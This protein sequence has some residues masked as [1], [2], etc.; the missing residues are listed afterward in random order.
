L[1]LPESKIKVAEICFFSVT[2]REEAFL[3][4]FPVSKGGEPIYKI[5][6][7]F[8]LYFLFE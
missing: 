7:A 1:V 6:G 5:F 2:N 8:F 4:A 3:A